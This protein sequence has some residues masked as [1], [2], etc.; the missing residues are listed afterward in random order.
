MKCRFVLIGVATACIL[1][2]MASAAAA[3]DLVSKP[4][5]YSGYSRAKYD[6]VKLTSQYVTMRDGTKIALDIYRPT[7]KGVEASEKFPVVWM[8]TP[9]NR[10][11]GQSGDAGAVLALARYGYAVVAADMRGNY[12]SFGRA[13]AE[14]GQASAGN[15]NEWMPWA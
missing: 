15:R 3:Q 10:R 8:N 14:P 6:G 7:L 9:Y 2:F 4:G 11:G 5:V 12:A 1:S 13:V